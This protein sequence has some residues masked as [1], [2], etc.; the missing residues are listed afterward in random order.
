MA[1]VLP[2]NDMQVRILGCL[3]EKKATTP[4]QYPLT[5]NALKNACN[6]KTNRYPVVSYDSGPIGHELR[7]LEKLHLVRMERSARAER[8]EHRFNHVLEL[9]PRDVAVL[10]TLMLRGPQTIAEIRAR[11]YKV[12]GLDDAE[13][14]KNVVDRLI[15]HEPPLVCLVPRQ[16]GQKEDRHTH[17][18]AGEPDFSQLPQSAPSSVGSRSHHDLQERV[19]HLEEELAAIKGLLENLLRTK[20]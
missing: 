1:S 3:I 2:L 8:Y 20:E 5:L 10:S 17:L 7:E 15:E 13:A 9:R 14:V 6:Q 11:T 19:E 18:I 16:P 12:L 4:D